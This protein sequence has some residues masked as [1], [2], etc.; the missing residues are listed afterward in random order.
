MKASVPGTR[1]AEAGCRSSRL[2]SRGPPYSPT[3][4]PS[5]SRCRAKRPSPPSPPPQ[6]A[7][8]DV[9]LTGP[10]AAAVSSAATRA[11]ASAS[12]AAASLR[13]GSGRPRSPPAKCAGACTPP[14]GAAPPR[15][16]NPP[17]GWS[18]APA[19]RCGCG[20]L[21]ARPP[22]TVPRAGEVAA[23]CVG[24]EGATCS[25]AHC[26]AAVV[27]TRH[28]GVEVGAAS[29]RTPALVAAQPVARGGTGERM[30]FRTRLRRRQRRRR[31]RRRRRWQRPVLRQLNDLVVWPDPDGHRDEARLEEGP[32]PLLAC[33]GR[34]ER[35]PTLAAGLPAGLR[36]VVTPPRRDAGPRTIGRGGR[37]F[38]PRR[39]VGVDS[40]SAI[41]LAISIS[42]VALA[43][44]R[45]DGGLQLARAQPLQMIDAAV[46][47]HGVPRR[48]RLL[49]AGEAAAEGGV[50]IGVSH[51][52]AARHRQLRPR[53]LVPPAP[54]PATRLVLPAAL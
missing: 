50:A 35:E 45:V 28:A 49:A 39:E 52:V 15:P 12:M 54:P 42:A 43:G 8:C 48:I 17:R 3:S 18:T 40:R 25:T 4:W 26:V 29:D 41:E 22:A 6:G 53:G 38:F 16:P 30:A 36:Q 11:A 47:A 31:R 1:S 44:D 34:E 19:S 21:R 46:L 32:P 23:A 24:C 33:R 13:V 10:H 37:L 5:R 9:A 2:G 7:R 51:H 14:D 20:R 27:I